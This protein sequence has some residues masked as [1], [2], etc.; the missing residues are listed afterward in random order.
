MRKKKK[1]K[2]RRRREEEKKKKKKKKK[3]EGKK[4]RSELEPVPTFEPSTYQLYYSRLESCDIA[5]FVPISLR[6]VRSRA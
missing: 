1:K 5:V 4:P 6:S 2:K 3:K